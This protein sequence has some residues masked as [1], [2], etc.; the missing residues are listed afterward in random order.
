[1]IQIL[2]RRLT[3]LVIVSLMLIAVGIV[4]AINYAN[5]QNIRNQ[6]YE[7]LETLMENEGQRP[8]ASADDSRRE[9]TAPPE[10]AEGTPPPL[11]E[12]PQAEDAQA[13]QTD[14][15][16]PPIPENPQEMQPGGAQP[17]KDRPGQP[18][19][20]DRAALAS[21]SN[22]YTIWLDED[23][24]V[25]EWTSDRQE[26]YD[27]EQVAQLAE[28]VWKSGRTRGNIGSQFYQM[29]TRPGGAILVVIDARSELANIRTLLLE[30]VA[31]TA[32]AFVL[33]AVGAALL[34]G[35]MLRPVEEAFVKQR[36]FVW[37]ASHE[38]KTPLAVV[39][40]NADVLA[41]E[42]GG[43][44]YLGYIRSE[45]TRTNTLVENLLTLARMD[46]GTRKKQAVRFDLSRALLSVALPFESAV[47]EA[48]KTL[49]IDVPQGVSMRGDEE[50]IKQLA[51]IL[52]SNALKYSAEG[53]AIRLSLA[54]RGN[55]RI[56][57][58]HNM[59][60]PIAKAD[61]AKIFDRF[62][63]ADASHNREK[64]GNGLGLAIAQKIVE[65][66]HGKIAVS[67]T[68]EAG[69]TFTATLPE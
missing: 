10:Q 46:S 53:S 17:E 22:S 69:T 36:Q 25:K 63:R 67:S 15:T 42:I 19:Q 41:D 57:S 33:L 49:E 60:E 2:R 16:P 37:D 30:T 4:L 20:P 52:L 59:G 32:L 1:M 38:L 54:A 50:M 48:G 39:S 64:Q 26:L 28:Q 51:V 5:M 62:Y 68:K 45:V 58:V 55:K 9:E 65:E 7:T 47:F 23:G 27:D 29:Q 31:V 61:Q 6:M 56:L 44:E 66:H 21:L 3:A 43:N 35:R 12:N 18:G 24:A 40:A 14:E 11:P 34:I 8:G 13:R